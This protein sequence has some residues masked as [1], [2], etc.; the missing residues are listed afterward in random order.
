VLF[1]DFSYIFL[2]SDAKGQ[3]FWLKKPKKRRYNWKNWRLNLI[4]KKETTK[5]AALL[6]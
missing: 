5:G 4:A 3:K 1:E 2:A 6:H